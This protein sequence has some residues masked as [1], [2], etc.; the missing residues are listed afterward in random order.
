MSLLLTDSFEGP[1]FQS[2]ELELEELEIHDDLT[3]VVLPLR[4]LEPVDAKHRRSTSVH[5]SHFHVLE[6]ASSHEHVGSQEEVIGMDQ[7]ST[8]FFFGSRRRAGSP[9]Q[10]HLVLS[11]DDAGSELR[12]EGRSLW[13]G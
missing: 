9:R 10:H 8:S 13:M 12:P 1:V 3:A 7:R 4:L 2:L 5:P 6:P 11:S